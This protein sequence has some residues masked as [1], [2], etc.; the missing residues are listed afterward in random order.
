MTFSLRATILG[1]AAPEHRLSCP[2]SLWREGIT[3]LARRGEG[4]HESGAFLLGTAHGQR[5]RVQRFVYFDDLDPGCLDSGIV[6]FDGAG[7]GPL[8]AVCRQ[9]G[10]RVVADTH[11]HGGPG[12]ARQ[13]PLD[14]DNPMVAQRG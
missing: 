7:F 6:V 8:W 2:A 14:R 5:R 1:L 9:T 13:S 4:Q 10:L 11:T 3:E 12:P